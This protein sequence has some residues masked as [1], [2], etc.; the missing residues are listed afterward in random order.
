VT[1]R[2]CDVLLKP[3]PN[4]GYTVTVPSLPGCVAYG[5]DINEALEAARQAIAAH[6]ES[7]EKRAEADADDI[8]AFEELLILEDMDAP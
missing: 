7:M 4:G 5:A 8:D 6:V 2:T 3:E 1:R